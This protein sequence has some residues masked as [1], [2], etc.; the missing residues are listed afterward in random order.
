MALGG[1][2]LL[3]ALALVACTGVQATPRSPPSNVPATVRLPSPQASAVAPATVRRKKDRSR[4]VYGAIEPGGLAPSVRGLIPRVYVPNNDDRSVSVID[5]R[6]YRVVRTLWWGPNR[7]TSHRR[8]I[9]ATSMWA[10][11]TETQ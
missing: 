9:C 1:G 6:T 4:G 10:T 11:S 7:S 5:P 2:T 3:L 8:G